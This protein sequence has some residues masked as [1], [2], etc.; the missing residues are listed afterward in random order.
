[1]GMDFTDNLDAMFNFTGMKFNNLADCEG[2]PNAEA[3]RFYQHVK[4]GKQPLYP[5]C[6]NFSRL[7][8]MVRLFI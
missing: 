3:K 8:F 4:E 6:T 5:G 1:M 7:S 2:V